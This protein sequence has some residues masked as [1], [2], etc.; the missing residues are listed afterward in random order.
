MLSVVLQA[1]NSKEW[2]NLT[3]TPQP[4]GE[5]SVTIAGDHE[6]RYMQFDFDDLQP[7]DVDDLIWFL[8]HRRAQLKPDGGAQ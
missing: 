7:G 8:S 6:G 5:L 4:D 3:L 2:M 1:R